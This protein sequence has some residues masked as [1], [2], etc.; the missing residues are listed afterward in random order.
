MVY[1]R[2][3][4]YLLKDL[5]FIQRLAIQTL[6]NRAVQ[7]FLNVQFSCIIQVCVCVIVVL[8]GVIILM[9]YFQA[10]TVSRKQKM[11]DCSSQTSL[12]IT[13]VS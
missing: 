2:Y 9:F 12:M 8:T 7:I 4:L 13:N 10:N 5:D 3:L 6:G 11:R 1:N